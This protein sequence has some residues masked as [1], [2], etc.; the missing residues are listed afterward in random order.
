MSVCK[1]TQRSVEDSC[2]EGPFDGR[3]AGRVFGRPQEAGGVQILKSCDQS[4]LAANNCAGR[5]SGPTQE[6]EC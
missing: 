1:A 5:T 4:R 2:R 6:L 3:Q